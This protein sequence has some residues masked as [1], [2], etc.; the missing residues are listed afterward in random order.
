MDLQAT[1]QLLGNFGEF[2]GAIAVVVTLGYLAVQ[3]RH[4]REATEANTKSLRSAARFEAGKCWTEEALQLALSPD[5]ATIVATGFENVTRLDDNQRQRLVAWNLQHFF[6]ADMLYQQYVEGVL[7]E[8]IW[9]A[10]E[11][12]IVGS[13]QTEATLRLW[14]AGRLTVSSGF[15]EYLDRLRADIPEGSWSWENNARLFDDLGSSRQPD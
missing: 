12:I 14:D 5:M 2:F 9:R 6:M 11:R 15:K 8:D 3:V 13:L 1:A 4:G 7:P 10:H